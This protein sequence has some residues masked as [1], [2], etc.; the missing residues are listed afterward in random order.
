MSVIQQISHS[1]TVISADVRRD[2]VMHRD[3]AR[4]AV[5]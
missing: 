2:I 1:S 3:G 5:R 4:R